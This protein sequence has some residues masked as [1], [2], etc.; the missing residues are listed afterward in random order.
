VLLRASQY[1]TGPYLDAETDEPLY[2]FIS[3]PLNLD[4]NFMAYT[5]KKKDDKEE[6]DP[7]K[8]EENCRKT[9]TKRIYSTINPEDYVEVEVPYEMNL[10]GSDGQ[11]WKM[12]LQTE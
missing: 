7:V 9:V 5:M 2:D 6:L 11:P 3:A 1:V 4:V 8:L 12:K 10:D